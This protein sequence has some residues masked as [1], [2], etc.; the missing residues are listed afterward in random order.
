MERL[1]IIIFSLGI[2]H[3]GYLLASQAVEAS[4]IAEQIKILEAENRSL[5]AQIA[6]LTD[7]IEQKQAGE[8]VD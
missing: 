2:V 1:A 6:Q 8:L 5:E 7:Q 4:A 3:L